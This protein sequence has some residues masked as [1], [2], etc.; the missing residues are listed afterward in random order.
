MKMNEGKSII[1]ISWLDEHTDSFSNSFF[2]STKRVVYNFVN[3]AEKASLDFLSGTRTSK[4]AN[5]LRR[6]FSS[7]CEKS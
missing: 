5:D 4:R 6:R 2:P 7:E 1:D 3:D